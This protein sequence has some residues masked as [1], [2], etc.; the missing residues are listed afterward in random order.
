MVRA[1]SDERTAA[2]L[3]AHR[4]RREAVAGAAHGLDRRAAER[5]VELVAQVADV[6]LD[7]VRVALEVVVPDVVEDVALR[8][9]LALAAQQVL[10]QRE[11]AR[12][13]VDSAPAPPRGRRVE[14]E[15]A[16]LEHGRP[17]GAPRRTSARRRATSTTYENG[18][19]R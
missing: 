13:Q 8:H 11:L 16:G 18:F 19:V 12:R 10:E 15:V 1:R 6:D 2:A 9:D 3:G 17:L 7:D 4:R 14:P 5:P